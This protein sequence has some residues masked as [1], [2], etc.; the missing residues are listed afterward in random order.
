M[1]VTTEGYPGPYP[2]GQNYTWEWRV[3]SG[4]WGVYIMELD[5]AGCEDDPDTGDVLTITDDLL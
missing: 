4:H 2:G 1:D 5:L 3:A